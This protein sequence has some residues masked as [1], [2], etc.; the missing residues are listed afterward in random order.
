M[1]RPDSG[2]AIAGAPSRLGSSRFTSPRRLFVILV[3]LGFGL[4]IGYGVVR[5]RSALTNLSGSAFINAWN[6]D[7]LC[8]VLIAEALLSGK[9]YIV[10]AAPLAPGKKTRYAGQEALFKAPLY[11]FFLAGTFAIS[12]F[13][14]KLFFHS[15]RCLADSR[16]DLWV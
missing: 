14:F 10:D 6:A 16:P 2:Y 1:S 15:K 9:G 5:Y 12:G 8:H 3:I 13:S 11:E 7:A 4:R